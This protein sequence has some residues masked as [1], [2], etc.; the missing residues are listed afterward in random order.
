MSST[1]ARASAI[2]SAAAVGDE[3]ECVNMLVS[4][5]VGEPYAEKDA[6]PLQP[7]AL[8]DQR[9]HSHHWLSVRLAP[10]YGVD[11]ANDSG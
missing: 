7:I 2:R 5:D 6:D 10:H 1:P 4:Q 11:G 8:G 9:T 3:I